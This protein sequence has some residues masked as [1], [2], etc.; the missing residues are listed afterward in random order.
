MTSAAREC[1]DAHRGRRRRAAR[2]ELLDL[3]CRDAILRRTADQ[4]V[5]S[6][7]GTSARWMLD[8]L[9]VT[10]TP[11]GAELAARALLDVLASFEGRQLAT[12]GLTGVP[13]LQGCVLHGGGRYS[14]VLVRKERKAHGSLKL[15]E[16]RLDRAEPVVMVDDSI[17]SGQSM[18][19]CARRLEEA[20]FHVEGGVGLVHFGYERG[21]AR[22]V[23]HGY[24][25]AAVFDIF[26][27]L[28]PHIDGEP[29]AA[30][31]PD[32]D[33]GRG[34]VEPGPRRRGQPPRAPGA[35]RDGRVPALR[36]GAARTRHARPHL[37]G[38]RGLLGQPAA[39]GNV[40]DR[41][42]RDGFWHFPGEPAG[43]VPTDVVLA[44]VQTAGRLRRAHPDAS[45]R[46]SGTCLADCAVAVTFF[47][48]LA[49]VHGRGA[50][51]RPVRDRRAQ[52][53]APGADGRRAAADARDRDG[54]AAVRARRLPQRAPAA[55]ARRTCSTG[56]TCRRSSSRARPGSRRASRWAIPPTRRPPGSPRRRR[57]GCST[58][59]VPRSTARPRPCPRS[60]CRRERSAPS[61]P[62]TPAARL[63]GCAGGFGD[64]SARRR[65]LL[66]ASVHAAV[67]DGRF[68]AVAPADRLA[69]GLSLL[70]DR[71]EIGVA[72]P[73]WVVR[74]VRFADQALAVHQGDRHGFVLPSVA[75]THN[76]TP[77]SYVAE[78]ID[79]AGITRP[80]VPVDPLRLRD[81][82]GRL[83]RGPPDAS[84]PA[85][86][87]PRGDAGGTGGAAARAVPRLRAPATTCRP[88]SPTAAATTP[89]PT[90]CT[91]A[92]TR[93]GSPTGRGPWPAPGCPR[94]PSTTWAVPSSPPRDRRSRTAGWAPTKPDGRRAGLRGPRP[95]RA[96]PAPTRR[97]RCWPR[98]CTTGSTG[99]AGSRRTATRRPRPRRSRTTPPARCCSR[100]P[101][102]PAPGSSTPSP[103]R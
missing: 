75:V 17:S 77:R 64:G 80:P 12:L 90:G 20:G 42:A 41:P 70:S 85:G 72:T 10:L 58:W 40:H 29:A 2:A 103:P 38:G 5:L 6:R 93:H 82:A 30:R 45:S 89:S 24:R 69:V 54:L 91:P 101:R 15:V 83:L 47:D 21:M 94:P 44:A 67:H 56:T 25:A 39:R 71:H 51:R 14:G 79:K 26:T 16:G 53:G 100:W 88:A 27:D 59:S 43:P 65:R 34:R 7:D 33:R 61:S 48:A 18:L 63:A 36:S 84:R 73:D 92:R 74:P 28:M 97:R 13:L 95:A 49:G 46:R 102:P 66:P 4:P 52:P 87:S 96:R 11:R 68:R 22:M 86:R 62:C 76:L 81:L 23:E 98:R 19:T 31:E 55:A 50:G 35:R 60:H 37:P 9:A 99:T 78:V 8:S 57:G 3:L 1:D 32:E